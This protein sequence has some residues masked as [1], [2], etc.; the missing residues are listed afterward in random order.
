MAVI[1]VL[2]GAARQLLVDARAQAVDFVVREKAESINGRRSKEPRALAMLP[3]PGRSLISTGWSSLA[4]P[5]AIKIRSQV[6]PDFG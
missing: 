5:F 1:F 6:L 4:E 3:R 2:F